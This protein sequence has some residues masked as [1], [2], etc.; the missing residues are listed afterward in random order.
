VNSIQF[1]LDSAATPYEKEG[2]ITMSVTEKQAVAPELRVGTQAPTA[3]KTGTDPKISIQ[4]VT[5]VFGSGRE[6]PVHALGPI[7]L[8]IAEGEFVS[9]VGPSG[10]G[11]STL[12]RIVAGLLPPTDGRIEVNGVKNGASWYGFV[13]QSSSAFPWKTVRKNVRMGLDFAGKHSRAEKRA[14]V[15]RW[16]AK[17]G[18][19]PFA[20]AL[21]RALSGGMR[22]RMAIA[23]A[24]AI[25]PIVLLMDEPFAA[26]DAQMRLLLQ[27]ELLALWEQEPRTVLFITHSIDEALLL[28]DR[29]L[30]CSAR[31]GLITREFVVPFARPRRHDIRGTA[32]FAAMHEEIWTSL[33]AEVDVQIADHTVG[34]GRAPRSRRILGRS[35]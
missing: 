13:P 28:S 30:L 4:G 12:L 11:K 5:R 16:L 34:A 18:L 7:D 1:R 6:T 8:D 32:D 26:L 9:V 25:D 19:T 14:I 22:Q 29:V 15:D 20:E 2:A 10:C 33:K 31:P 3:A 24:L 27:E 23:R 35:K 21:P 17:T